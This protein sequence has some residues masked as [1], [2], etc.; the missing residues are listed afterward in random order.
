[1]RCLARAR[2]DMVGLGIERI[3]NRMGWESDRV[4]IRWVGNRMRIW[5]WEWD[6]ERNGKIKENGKGKMAKPHGGKE[7]KGGHFLGFRVLYG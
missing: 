5:I 6:K 4:G 7:G 3:G 1:M 2:G